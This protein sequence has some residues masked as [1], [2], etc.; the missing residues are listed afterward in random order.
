[1]HKIELPQNNISS[2][3]FNDNFPRKA[4]KRTKVLIKSKR[5]SNNNPRK[6]NIGTLYQREHIKF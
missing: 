4:E 2:Q 6:E 5:K 3:Q 1:M